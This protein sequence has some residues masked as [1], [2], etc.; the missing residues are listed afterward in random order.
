MARRFYFVEK[1]RLSKVNIKEV[2]KYFVNIW[3]AE[4]RLLFNKELKLVLN[5]ELFV[6]ADLDD[7][8]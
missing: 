2:V 6:M 1:I 8:L 7:A 5:E 3:S 4:I